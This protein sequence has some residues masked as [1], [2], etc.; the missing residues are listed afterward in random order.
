MKIERA[1]IEDAPAILALQKLAYQSEARIHNDY[2]I[3]PLTQ[4]LDELGSE[5]ESG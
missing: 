1:L 3:Q 4:T 5:F 2:S